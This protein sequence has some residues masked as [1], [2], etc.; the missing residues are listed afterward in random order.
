MNDDAGAEELCVRIPLATAGCGLMWGTAVGLL[1]WDTWHD[2][3]AATRWGLLF[4]IIGA[5]WTVMLGIR[6]GRQW[7]AESV[8]DSVERRVRKAIQEE[9]IASLQVARQTR[10]SEDV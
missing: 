5:V 8:V 1:S 2:G 6:S 10:V 9:Q 7:V 4:A 3:M